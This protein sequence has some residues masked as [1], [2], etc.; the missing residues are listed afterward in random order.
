MRREDYSYSGWIE[1]NS[2]YSSKD[3]MDYIED[4]TKM[5]ETT[6]D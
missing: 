5:E 2:Y 4:I 3:S 1:E 6:K